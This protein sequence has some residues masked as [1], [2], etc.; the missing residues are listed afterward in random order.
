MA[1]IAFIL[2]CHKDPSA[3][4]AQAERL[5]ARGDYLSIHFDGRAPDTAYRQITEALA[6]NPN[7]IFAPRRVKCGWGEW[8]L[9]E[10][11]LVALQA[12]ET[13]FKDATHFYM[14]SGDCMPVKSAHYAH[15]WLDGQDRDFIESFDFFNSGWI[16]TG[17]K[18]DR[19]YYRHF[20]NERNAKRRFYASLNIQRWLRLR[21]DLPAD[22]QVMIG[23]QWWC[24]R[25]ATVE[26]V[27]AFCAERPDVMR[28]FRTTWI[29]DETFFQ[30]LVRHLVA[31][32]EIESRTLTFL[33]FSDYGMPANFYNDQ[34]DLLVSQN[35]LF[36]RKISP[37]ALELKERLGAL[38]ESDRTDFVP[39]D[40]GKQLFRFMTARGRVGRRFAPRFWETEGSLGRDRELLILTCKK[41]HIAKR[42][43]ELAHANMGLQGVGFL[44]NEGSAQLPPLGGIEKT[45]EKRTRHRRSLMRMLFDYYDT[46]RLAICLDPADI[47]LMQDFYG[48]KARTRLLEIQCV[49]SDD[50]LEGHARRIGIA[51]DNTSEA[52][53][54]A[55][56]PT[57]RYEIAFEREQIRDAGF[58]DVF[59]MREDAPKF[60]QAAALAGF[61]DC[62]DDTARRIADTSYLF[63]D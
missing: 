46:N 47:E 37:G 8:S 58:P 38:W 50:Y 61:F 62:D 52:T 44:F 29:P 14:T 24:L 59:R 35:H 56:L 42:V 11:T 36:A 5:T 15:Y 30:T 26:K 32:R 55:L 25:R 23:S 3:I 54:A 9:V 18:D 51:S 39:S 45:V 43:L 33:M 4:V 1:R 20:F 40:E 21:R 12:A 16:K 27:L 22:I 19:L 31:E 63:S 6:D 49:F 41:W 57:I 60:E 53:M 7:V 28:F 10:A 48:D 34:Y 13:A 2:L 17:M